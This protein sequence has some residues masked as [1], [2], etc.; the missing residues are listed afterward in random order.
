L[1]EEEEEAQDEA[2]VPARR[3]SLSTAQSCHNRTNTRV[4]VHHRSHGR[5]DGWMHDRSFCGLSLY[6]LPQ[7]FN[8]CKFNRGSFRWFWWF[9]VRFCHIMD[10]NFKW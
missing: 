7:F 1:Q 8:S 9:D 2:L 3:W 6:I 10:R 4:W 5:T